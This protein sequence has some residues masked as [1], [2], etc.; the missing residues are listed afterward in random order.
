MVHRRKD[1]KHLP[2]F[3]NPRDGAQT[4]RVRCR[5]FGIERDYPVLRSCGIAAVFKSRLAP[6]NVISSKPRFRDE[7]QKVLP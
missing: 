5:G 2:C 3:R 1:F 4:F 6:G 7:I